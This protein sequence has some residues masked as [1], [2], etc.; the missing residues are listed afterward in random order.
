MVKINLNALHAARKSFREAESSEKIQE[1]LISNIK[2]YT[3]EEFVTGDTIIED[4]TARD[5]MI[6]L[7]YWVRKVSVYWSDMAEHL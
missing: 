3:D 1:A 4:K 6:L 2:T 5:D 7:K